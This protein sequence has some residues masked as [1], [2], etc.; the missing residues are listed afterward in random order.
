MKKP[1]EEIYDYTLKAVER[2]NH[3]EKCL[4]IDDKIENVLV[5]RNKGMRAFHFRDNEDFTADQLLE[6][7][8]K[9]YGILK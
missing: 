1:D 3:P 2:Q 8:L 5:A 7:E 9:A 4:F 6:W